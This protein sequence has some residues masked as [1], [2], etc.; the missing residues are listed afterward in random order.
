MYKSAAIDM[1]RADCIIRRDNCD[2]FLGCEPAELGLDSSWAE[3]RQAVVE[4]L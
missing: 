4:S 3:R 1:P 2:F